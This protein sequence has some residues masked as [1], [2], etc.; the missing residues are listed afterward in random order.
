MEAEVDEVSEGHVVVKD[1]RS[2]VKE[3]GLCQG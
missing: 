1:P 3:S 2:H